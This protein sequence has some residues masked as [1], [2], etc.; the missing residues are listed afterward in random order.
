MSMTMAAFSGIA[1]YIAIE[2]N[3]R[4]FY[5]FKRRK[6]IYF[7]SCAI[8]SWGILL[9]PLAIILADFQVI[10]D[11]RV[12]IPFIYLSWWLMTIPFSAVMYSRL[13][14]I[15][16]NWKHLRWVLYLILFTTLFVSVPSMVMGPMSQQPTPAGKRVV[17][18][19]SIWVKIENA[20]WQVQETIISTL[21]IIY[22]HKHLRDTPLFSDK[23]SRP[24]TRSS[25]HHRRHQV[26]HHLIA[27]NILII[28]LDI[29]LIGI[30]YANLFYLGGSMKPAV[31]GIKLRVEF[32][33]LN[34]LVAMAQ[35]SRLPLSRSTPTTGTVQTR[36]WGVSDSVSRKRDA[37]EE[38]RTT[39]VIGKKDFAHG[40]F[41]FEFEEGDG[42]KQ[43]TGIFV[44]D[45]LGRC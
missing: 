38:D 21:Y 39:N 17:P 2:L 37:D 44:G 25:T 30:V 29:T 10:L 34:R 28:A 40:A 36:T 43:P 35:A 8:C 9:H 15:M 16:A 12:S 24:S 1:W 6:G 3:V 41:E 19:Y 45:G 23:T 20:T 27:T 22:T 7:W 32:S 13:H 14:L 18:I 5:L 4:L 11:T 42:I 31:Y 33:I 26:M